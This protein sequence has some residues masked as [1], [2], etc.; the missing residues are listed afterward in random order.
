MPVPE[1]ETSV[2]PA[3]AR[4]CVNERRPEHERGASDESAENWYSRN[5]VAFR[6]SRR[7]R[8][9]S[10]RWL[11]PAGSRYVGVPNVSM[12]D[13]G[14]LDLERTTNNPMLDSATCLALGLIKLRIDEENFHEVVLDAFKRSVR[15]SR[16]C[17]SLS[18]SC[19]P[20]APPCS[21]S[22]TGGAPIDSKRNAFQLGVQA[23]AGRLVDSD[24][25]S[26][27]T[28]RALRRPP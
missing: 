18:S 4:T 3:L 22:R 23:H 25:S 28:R 6:C 1:Y 9:R 11:L 12:R 26:R 19:T 21:A 2:P 14:A 24:W 7:V 13:A 16:W 17:T 15:R 10:P 27:S 5:E 20:S 8:V